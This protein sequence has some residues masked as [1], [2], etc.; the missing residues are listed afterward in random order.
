M[1][2][3]VTSAWERATGRRVVLKL[4][5]DVVRLDGARWG[6]VLSTVREGLTNVA[7]HSINTQVE[8]EVAMTEPSGIWV[9]VTDSV[10]DPGL[11]RP[12]ALGG[13]HGLVGLAE[14]AALLGGAAVAHT[15]PQGWQLE[16]SVP[17]LPIP[18]QPSV[19]PA[20]HT[21]GRSAEGC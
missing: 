2:K 20:D 5:A 11:P 16:L 7:R 17:A 1:L 13:G 12:P 8:V 6:A 18:P 4:P 15:T 19:L 10:P 14:R 9:R 21:P 3:D